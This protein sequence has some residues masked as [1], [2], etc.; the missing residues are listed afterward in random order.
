MNSLF[1][2]SERNHL[3]LILMTEL[4]S[5]YKDDEYVTLAQI[6]EHM[7]ISQGYL[8]EIAM[9]L[10]QAGLIEGRKGPN[11]GYRLAQHPDD[12]TA[13]K[14]LSALEGPLA[15]VECQRH[16]SQCPAVGKCTSKS[17]WKVLQ[18][19]LLSTLNQTTLADMLK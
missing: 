6:A 14:I 16:D 9:S 8:E 2:V 4:A 19:N 10:K 12:I 11:G 7:R 13:E 3:G 15:L 5:V 1:H 17:F 18:T